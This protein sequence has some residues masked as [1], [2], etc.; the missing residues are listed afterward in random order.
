M[1]SRHRRGRTGTGAAQACRLATAALALSAAVA[2]PADQW[3]L[4]DY[5]TQ[6]YLVASGNRIYNGQEVTP[7]GRYSFLTA[8]QV[9]W[10][11]DPAGTCRL[12][13]GSLITPTAVLTAAHCFK[14]SADK[15]RSMRVRLGAHDLGR[16]PVLPGGGDIPWSN[17]VIHPGER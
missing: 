17:I 8:L 10:K 13:G 9:C 6:Y 16:G 3:R 1:G 4:L 11:S 14:G 15:V 7:P 5:A 2:A 12:C